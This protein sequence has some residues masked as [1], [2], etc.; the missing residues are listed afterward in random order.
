MGGAILKSVSGLGEC[1]IFD[2]ECSEWW[3]YT[4]IDPDYLSGI[5]SVLTPVRS[6][7]STSVDAGA[8]HLTAHSTCQAKAA[9]TWSKS[10]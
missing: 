4:R 7:E 6:K 9:R 2:K 3:L 10:A 5:M 1:A 8:L